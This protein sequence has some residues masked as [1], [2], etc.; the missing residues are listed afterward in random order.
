MVQVLLKD[1]QQHEEEMREERVRCDEERA[2]QE[3]ET[4]QQLDLL[5]GLLEGVLK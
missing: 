2:K 3:E 4:Q 1:R 5:R